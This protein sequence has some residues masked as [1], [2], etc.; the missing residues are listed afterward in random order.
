MRLKRKAL[1]ERSKAVAGESNQSPFEA[2]VLP[3]RSKWRAIVLPKKNENEPV[4]LTDP[5]GNS[6]DALVSGLFQGSVNGN[7]FRAGDKRKLE[8]RW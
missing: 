4:R 3:A 6:H 8:D 1:E 2:S 5:E 7:G